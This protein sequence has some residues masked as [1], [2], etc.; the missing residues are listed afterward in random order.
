MIT[1]DFTLLLQ[2]VNMAVLMF[3]LNRVLYRPV[4]RVLRERAEKLKGMQDE[5]LDFEVKAGQQQKKVDEKMAEASGKAKAALDS[6]R[7]EAQEAGAEKLSAIKAEAEAGKDE[8]LLALKADVDSARKS[9]QEG[10]DDFATEM[11]SKILG[12]SL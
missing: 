10:L 5:I 2:I 11:A 3:L 8:K 4:R 9:L 7:A 12:R 1:I 6:A